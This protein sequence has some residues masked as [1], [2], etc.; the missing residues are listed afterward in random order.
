MSAP[1]S[2]FTAEEIERTAEVIRVSFEEL[3]RYPTAIFN[4]ICETALLPT[5]ELIVTK[6]RTSEILLTQRE[7]DDPYFASKWHI[8]GV[9]V[10]LHDA[11]SG[12]YRDAIDNA[13]MRARDELEGTRITSMMR[14]SPEW[15]SQ[16]P[17][18]SNRG[19]EISTFYGA[20][21]IDDE[22][23]VGQMFDVHALPETVLENH[24]ELAERALS[25]IQMA[26]ASLPMI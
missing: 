1:E 19:G 9:M 17:R 23:K 7:H 15:L 3:G 2:Q 22:P 16:P 11:Q 12:P 6:P 25:A 21:L 14:L 18:I 5:V 4:A 26:H 8:P 10:A 13:A 24:R 20:Y